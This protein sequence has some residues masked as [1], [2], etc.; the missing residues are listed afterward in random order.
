[1]DE[2]LRGRLDLGAGDDPLGEAREHLAR[3]GLDEAL[4]AGVVQ[5]G[6]RLAPA[7]GADERLGELLADVRERLRG[8]AG[9]D[10]EGAARAARP[11]RARRGTAATAGSIE[12]EWNAPATGRRIVRLP[13]SRGLGLGGARSGRGRRRGRSGPG[14]LSLATVRPAALG[15]LRRPRPRRRRR[16]RSSSRRASASAIRRPRSTTS[17]SA[18]SAVRTPAAARAASSPS[19]WPA[20]AAARVVGSAR[21]PAIEAQKMA[22]CWKRVL[23]STRAKGSSPTSSRQ[24]SSSSGPRCATRSRMSGV[25]DP[26][27]GKSTA[28][29]TTGT[30]PPLPTRVRDSVTVR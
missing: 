6:E 2:L 7:D 20:A 29:G 1:M 9:E 17:S 8:R 22:G 3:A 27:P 18:S 10:G 25:W 21:Q 5:R 13:S 11:R 12:G 30:T 19:E 4:R 26:C 24:R 15:D 14:A 23:S 28:V 16:A